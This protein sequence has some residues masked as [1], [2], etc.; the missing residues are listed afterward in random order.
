[1]IELDNELYS[2]HSNLMIDFCRSRRDDHRR[3]KHNGHE[4]S[5]RVALP[6]QPAASITSITSITSI[7][8]S[9]ADSARIEE[10]GDGGRD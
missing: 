7:A 5:Q 1:M 3:R 10:R 6:L 9:D 2:I 8:S 4:S